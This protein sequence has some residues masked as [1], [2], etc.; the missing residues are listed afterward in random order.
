M[1]KKLERTN[2]RDIRDSHVNQDYHDMRDS[3]VDLDTRDMRDSHENP[4]YRDNHGVRN[5]AR[6]AS[7]DFSAI[8]L[9]T[10]LGVS[11][12][13]CVLV[14]ILGGI[15]L[16]GRLGTSPGFL[17]AGC[18]LGTAASFKSMYDITAKYR[19]PPNIKQK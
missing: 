12:S 7:K 15:W 5:V 18:L 4:D 9:F 1:K 6:R 14:G 8:A 11:M 3:Y 16:D 19:K 13:A 2:N 10:Q 17:F